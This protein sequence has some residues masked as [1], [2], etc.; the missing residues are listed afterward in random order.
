MTP[1]VL[2]ETGTGDHA[3]SRT[4]FKASSNALARL[5]RKNAPMPALIDQ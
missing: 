4:L 1:D 5:E 3:E 2:P